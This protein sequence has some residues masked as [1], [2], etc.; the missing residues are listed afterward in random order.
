MN[1][2]L[3]TLLL[4]TALVLGG[5]GGDNANTPSADTPGAPASLLL[6]DDVGDAVGII[7][8]K[9]GEAG[10]EIAVVGRVQEINRDGYAVF[11][12]VDD[13]IDYCG[14]GEEDCGCKTPWDYCC[15]EQQMREARMPVELRG[16]GG[17]PVKSSEL[18]LRLLDLVAVKG[19]LEK[20]DEGGLVLL[21]K[22][23]WYRRERP[24][25]PE[26]VKWPDE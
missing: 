10:A 4:S 9:A 17:M 7:D 8:A 14:R 5:C 19:T 26:G 24:T 12:L 25:I 22:D 1:R 21:A 6:A 16:P 15:D 11:Y 3:F 2:L 13:S 18:G 23:G 20:T